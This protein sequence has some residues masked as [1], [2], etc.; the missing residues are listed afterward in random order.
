MSIEDIDTYKL[1][2]ELSNRDDVSVGVTGNEVAL[3]AEDGPGARYGVLDLSSWG[4]L[5]VDIDLTMGPGDYEPHSVGARATVNVRILGRTVRTETEVDEYEYVD[6]VSAINDDHEYLD[7]ACDAGMRQ[8]LAYWLEHGS[9]APADADDAAEWLSE[10]LTDVYPDAEL[11]LKSTDDAEEPRIVIPERGHYGAVEDAVTEEPPTED[12][13]DTIAG[14]LARLA[15]ADPARTATA[16]LK[17]LD[18]YHGAREALLRE[19]RELE[20]LGL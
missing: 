15:H 8:A 1:L 14:D 19:L 3:V 12:A 7:N 6:P 4:D 18:G 11:R 9:H 5:E 17:A 13:R 10:A 2:R 20:D 16:L